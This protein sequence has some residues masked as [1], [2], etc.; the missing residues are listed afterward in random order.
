MELNPIDGDSCPKGAARV[1]GLTSA[2]KE[3]SLENIDLCMFAVPCTY[4]LPFLLPPLFEDRFL[5][6]KDPSSTRS[7]GV[8]GEQ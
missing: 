3:L 8:L 1:P 2:K 4:L 5:F 6:S 7:Y